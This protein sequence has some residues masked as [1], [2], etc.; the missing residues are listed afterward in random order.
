VNSPVKN[1]TLV[2]NIV[3]VLLII[4]LVTVATRTWMAPQYPNRVDVDLIA[5]APKTLKPLALSRKPQNARIIGSAVQ[6]N[7]FRQDRKEYSPPPVQIAQAI[8]RP[9]Q[10]ALPPP[11]LKLKGVLLL[12]TKKIAIMEGNY[13]VREGNQ[14]IKKMPLKRKG[15]PLGTKIGNYELTKIEKTQ[16]TLDDNRGAILNLNLKQRPDDKIIRKVGNSLVQKSKTFDPRKIK[17][18]S[19]PRKRS[20]TTLKKTVRKPKPVRAPRAFR[21]SGAPT[22]IPG[23]FRPHVSGR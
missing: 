6:G 2:S 13:P 20:T 16:V 11:N 22:K 18:P 23:A 3:L 21:I 10:P 7:L 4:A 19:P 12:G 15:Y 8:P 14:A 1:I 17:K 5:Y 9:A